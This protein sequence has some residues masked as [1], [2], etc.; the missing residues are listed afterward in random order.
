MDIFA[1]YFES[2]RFDAKISVV[3]SFRNFLIALE[4]NPSYQLFFQELHNPI[5]I[6][7]VLN[8]ISLIV[9]ESINLNFQHPK[10]TALGVYFHALCK[11]NPAYAIILNNKL[12][13]IVENLWWGRTVIR[14]VYEE[15][16][17]NHESV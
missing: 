10:D 16:K 6:N 17:Y 1:D 5:G 4:N 7:W 3:S 8:R 2:T 13:G 12:D 9:G 15:M 14:T 11:I